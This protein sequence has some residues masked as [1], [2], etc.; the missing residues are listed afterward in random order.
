V[1]VA[2]KDALDRFAAVLMTRVRDPAISECDRL[3]SGQTIGPRG[4]YWREFV[5]DDGARRAL[6]ALIPDVVDQ[7]LFELL[8]AADNHELP[9]AWQ[10]P[11]GSCL[12]LDE[13]GMQEMAGWLMGSDGW[14][15]R[16][17]TQRFHD[18]AGNLRLDLGDP[19]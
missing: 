7:V 15:R 14:R 17:S 3:A 6:E 10:E 12:P 9:L 4:D 2:D 18:P 1:L 8:N 5:T 11:D 19:Q 16:F 13:L